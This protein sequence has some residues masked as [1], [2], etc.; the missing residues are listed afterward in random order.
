MRI[1]TLEGLR[2]AIKATPGLYMK[3]IAHETGLQQTEGSAVLTGVRVPAKHHI[4]R[5]EAVFLSH[6]IKIDPMALWP[7]K[8][9]TVTQDDYVTIFVHPGNHY[10]RE[11]WFPDMVQYR[12]ARDVIMRVLRA[13]PRRYRTVLKLRYFHGMTLE[14]CIPYLQR[15]WGYRGASREGIRQIEEKGLK[16]LR[17]TSTLR[18]LETV[19][20]YWRGESI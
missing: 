10:K 20:E 19:F 13:M 6:G 12:E 8:Y 16:K 2:A 18:Q 11:H 14:E 5:L 9:A 15:V 4:P 7:S 1:S 17:H 3:T